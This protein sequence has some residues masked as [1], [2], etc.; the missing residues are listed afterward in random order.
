MRKRIFANLGF[1]L[2][3]S[4]LL[5]LIPVGVGLYFN[6]TAQIIPLFIVCVAFMGLGFLSN[7]LCERKDLDFKSSSLL[8]LI[9][10]LILPL[11]GSIPY[12][13]NDPFSSANAFERV[14]NSIFESVS[15]FTTTGFSFISNPDVLSRS[16]LVYRSLTELM[17]GV[18][19]VFLILA[20]FQSK[21][22]MSNLG[23]TL[24]VD[25]LNGN[26]KKMFA[27]VLGIYGAYIAVFMGLFY[28][29][30]FTDPIK[31]GSF[32]IDTL[33]GGFSPS[34]QQFSQF[35]L[36]APK[37]LI[38][39]LMLLGSVNFAFNYYLFTL[40]PKKM[41]S[42]EILGYFLIIAVATVA[43]CLSTQTAPID[44]LFHVVSMASSTGYDYLNIMSLNGTAVSI[45]ITL[46]LIGGCSFSMAGGIRVGRIV[47]FAKSLRQ[48]IKGIFIKEN[49]LSKGN[50]ISDINYSEYV[51]ALISIL[52][53]IVTLV[54]FAVL[55]TT[56]G[57]SFSDAI[58][59]MGSALSTNGVSMGAT[60]L[61]MPVAHKWLMIAAMII[62]RVEILTIIIALIP[63]RL[64]KKD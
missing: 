41:F 16:M 8:L 49:A 39:I 26:L 62:G 44:S 29:L 46:I 48:S 12:V 18:G 36:F 52:L 4:G 55:F 42:S 31:T 2:Q 40:K 6:E 17:G 5:T 58:F 15:G 11:I 14:T 28:G 33:T 38:I 30:G 57:V 3:V 47:T 27:Y 64:L 1:L 25:N 54:V 32:V 21:K 56:M 9:A 13:Y 59:E 34:V 24:G 63:Y 35:L 7:A 43:I 53:F 10:F 50:K 45:F 23:N 19:V 37:V 60:T 61:A 22:A 51:P 20:F